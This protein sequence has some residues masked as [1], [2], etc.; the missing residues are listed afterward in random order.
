MYIHQNHLN[1]TSNI[2]I[3]SSQ[4]NFK[5]TIR[6]ET[7]V[8]AIAIEV[9]HTFS[10]SVALEIRLRAMSHPARKIAYIASAITN[11]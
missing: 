7:N 3:H 8:I 4:W 10:P 6:T 5:Y 11:F 9:K 2:C 1:L